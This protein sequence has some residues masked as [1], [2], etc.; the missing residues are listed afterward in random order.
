MTVADKHIICLLQYLLT[1]FI[2]IRN[3]GCV[4]KL[5]QVQLKQ[6]KITALYR[7]YLA[8]VSVIYSTIHYS[9]INAHGMELCY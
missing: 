3:D 5:N 8:F 7:C 4:T 9:L 6:I 1:V 2:F